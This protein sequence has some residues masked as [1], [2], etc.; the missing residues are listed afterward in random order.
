[1]L[2]DRLVQHVGGGIVLLN[3]LHIKEQRSGLDDGRLQKQDRTCAAHVS[4]LIPTMCTLL[5]C[6]AGLGADPAIWLPELC[7]CCWTPVG[8]VPGSR[9]QYTRMKR[10]LR[11]ASMLDMARLASSFFV[12][13]INAAS[14]SPP[15]TTWSLCRFGKC[16]IFSRAQHEQ[17]HKA[18]NLRVS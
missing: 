15:N 12:Y 10:L 3:P 16:G 13:W 9:C 2:G 14:G 6:G 7:T 1:M 5:C 18:A 4:P 8:V 17:Q 11:T